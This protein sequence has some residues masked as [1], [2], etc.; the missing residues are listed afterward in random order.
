MKSK[1]DALHSLT[2]AA[3]Q[4]GQTPLYAASDKG[5]LPIMKSLLEY[6]GANVDASN[7]VASHQSPSH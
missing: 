7:E 4:D 3:S 2:L 1:R 6:K 5:H